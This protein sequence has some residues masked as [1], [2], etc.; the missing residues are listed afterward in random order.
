MNRSA[1]IA[2]VLIL[3]VMLGAVREFFFLNLNYAIDHLANHRAYSYAHSA[4]QAMVEGMTLQQL[5]LV[6]WVSAGLFILAMLG[7]TIRMARLLFYDHRYRSPIILLTVL[8]AVLALLL[9]FAGSWHPAFDLVSVK[10]LHLLQYPGILLFLWI[11][12]M[13][14]RSSAVA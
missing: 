14:R 6:K 8:I 1:G 4:F 10:L 3:A 13:L 7:I 12:S 11:A 9:H 5:V 2:L